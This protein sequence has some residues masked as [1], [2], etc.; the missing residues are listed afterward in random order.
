MIQMI[1]ISDIRI[2][3]DGLARI[4][5]NIDYID[6]LAT[7]RNVVEAEH[8]VRKYNPNILLI[9]MTMTDGCR[10]VTRLQLLSPD[11]KQ[12]ALAVPNDEQCTIACAKVGVMGYVSRESSLDELI[13]AVKKVNRGEFYCPPKIAATM[14]K[15][16]KNILEPTRSQEEDEHIQIYSSLYNGLTRRELQIADLLACGLSNKQI[17]RNLTIEVSTVKNHVHNILVKM[18]VDS[19]FKAACAFKENTSL[20]SL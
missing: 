10:T 12:I 17:A 8:A 19:R 2:Y 14:L 16:I 4:L 5:N 18:G 20:R 11:I 3:S 9:D 13:D 15:K 1:I 7:A 6:V